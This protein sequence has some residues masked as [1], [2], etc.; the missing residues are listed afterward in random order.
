M[1]FRGTCFLPRE[2]VVAEVHSRGVVLGRYRADSQGVVR[3]RVTIP[4]HID[5]GTHIFELEGRRSHLRLTGII[6]VTNRGRDGHGWHDD[7]RGGHGNRMGPAGSAQSL[8]KTGGEKALGLG[9]A[10]AGMIAVGGGTL[11]VM[12]RRRNS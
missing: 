3:G 7:G 2:T 1:S 9:G 11:L 12:R 6:R 4:R 8:A 10:A 5:R